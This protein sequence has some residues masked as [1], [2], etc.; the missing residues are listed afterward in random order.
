MKLALIGFGVVGQGLVRILHEKQKL[1]AEQYGF[2]G[3]IVAVADKIR[4]TLVHPEG[5]D[6]LA[7]LNTTTFETYPETPGLIRDLDSS[8]DVIRQSSADV[9]I[10]VTPTYLKTGEPA[11]SYCRLAL[12]TGKHVVTTNKGPIALA[13]AELSDLAR[14]KGLYLGFEGTVMAGTPTMTLGLNA[15]AGCNVSEIR[16]I[17][18][19]TTNYILTQMEAGQPYSAVLEEAQALGY[20]EADPTADVEGFDALSK[21]L[22]LAN[23]LMGGRLR[24]EDVPCKGITS[25]TL[26]DIRRAQQAQKRWKLIGSVR[27]D[28]GVI[29]ARVEPVLLPLSDPLASV[30]GVTN[31]I[32]FT[33]DL[34]GSITV[35]GPGAGQLPTGFAVLSDLL[36]IHRRG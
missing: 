26:E 31:A 28:N 18:N 4:G 1:L 12:E 3:R 14:Q 36:Q 5:L 16:G 15:L 27:H 6:P 10:E 34:L 19:G 8:E 17:L 32:T 2:H 30:S 11:L 9:M 25:L 24:V 21:V 22:I 20:A 23:T 29:A 33:T 35:V 13:Y 7:L